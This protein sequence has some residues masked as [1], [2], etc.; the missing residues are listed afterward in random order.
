MLLGRFRSISELFPEDDVPP[1]MW[2]RT[3]P[4]EH[5]CGTV[6]GLEPDRLETIALQLQRASLR[7]K[8]RE[9]S[10]LRKSITYAQNL[11]ATAR[12]TAATTKR[13]DASKLAR[14]ALMLTR[15]KSAAH[16]RDL[17]HQALQ[18]C[19]PPQRHG[20]MRCLVFMM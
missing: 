7:A 14:E 4:A 19:F 6:V 13:Q 17:V 18:I 8:G 11:A 2:L 15:V 10:E 20:M 3:A 1:A 16:M 5:A 9:Q 12:G